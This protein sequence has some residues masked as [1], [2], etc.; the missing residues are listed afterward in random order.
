MRNYFVQI[1]E[2]KVAEAR[3]KTLEERK[4][5][6]KNKMISCTNELKDVVSF[7]NATND[8]MTNYLIKLEEIDE[9]IA[10]LESEIHILNKNLSTMECALGQTKSIEFEIFLLKYKDNLKVKEIAKRKN[11]SIPRV[12]QYLNKINKKIGFKSKDYKKL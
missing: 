8:K 9:E 4:R 5:R 10:E 1:Q 6:L 12:Y 2:L 7:T 3:L 11:Y